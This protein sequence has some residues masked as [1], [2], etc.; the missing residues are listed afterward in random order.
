MEGR[1]T[2]DSE[3]RVRGVVRRWDGHKLRRIG[4]KFH[5]TWGD[6]RLANKV[7]MAVVARC[8]LCNAQEADGRLHRQ[9][10]LL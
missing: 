4:D 6:R 10:T 9:P 8:V 3:A 5:A 2:R 7:E 1:R